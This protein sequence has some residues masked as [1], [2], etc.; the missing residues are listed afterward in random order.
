M[1]DL[2]TERWSMGGT[3]PDWWVMG[4]TV[5]GWRV[6]GGAERFEHWRQQRVRGLWHWRQ[7]AADC[8]PVHVFS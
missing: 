6:A 7:Q 3:V 8:W 4:G 5:A 2:V 1:G